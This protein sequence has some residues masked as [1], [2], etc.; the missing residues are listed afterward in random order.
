MP[1]TEVSSR[2]LATSAA[3][4][5]GDPAGRTSTRRRSRSWSGCGSPPSPGLVANTG[6]S[7]PA[8]SNASS[9]LS[10]NVSDRRGNPLTTTARPARFTLAFDVCAEQGAHALADARQS[11]ELDAARSLARLRRPQPREHLGHQQLRSELVRLDHVEV[12]ARSE[13]PRSNELLLDWL[14]AGHQHGTPT[15]QQQLADGVVAGH[16]NHHVGLTEQQGKVR[17]EFEERDASLGELAEA[18]EE[19][20]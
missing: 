19:S 13:Q 8:A 2:R 20:C 14:R 15:E 7:M 9:S 17:F 16:G 1:T 5:A 6:P 11:I 10:A 3:W 4:S 12:A 18:P